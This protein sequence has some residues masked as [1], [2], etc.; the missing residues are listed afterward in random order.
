MSAANMHTVGTAALVRRSV[1]DFSGG[2][3]QGIFV[4]G[5]FVGGAQM[6]PVGVAY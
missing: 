4:L 1:G 5:D 3:N 6:V 2:D